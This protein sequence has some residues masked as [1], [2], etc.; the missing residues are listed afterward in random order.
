MYR[1]WHSS[2]AF[3]RYIVNHTVLSKLERDGEVSL[4][5]LPA[6][7]ASNPKTFHGVPTHLKQILYLD[8]PDLIVEL[9]N[10]PLF[11]VEVSEEAGTGH[12][13]FQRFG[14]IAAAVERGVPAFYIY[15]QAAHITRRGGTRW[16]RLNPTVFKT[17]DRLMEIYG[18]P[19]LLFYFPTDY[20]DDAERPPTSSPKGHKFERTSKYLRAPAASAPEMKALFRCIDAT[21]AK[22]QSRGVG[23]LRELIREGEIRS[24]RE[25]MRD[26]Y[27]AKG[28]NEGVWSPL[29]ATTTLP[30]TIV[31]DYIRGVVR[32]RSHI[33]G[34]L[35]GRP[36][37]VVYC[38]D[39]GFRGDPYPGALAAVDYLKCRTG[40]SYE[41]R[42]RNLV[43]AWGAL[44]VQDAKLHLTG[45]R[46]RSVDRF[47]SAVRELYR[48]KSRVLLDRRYSELA[49]ADIPRYYMQVRF[50][51]TFTKRKD[52]RMYSYFADALLFPDGV[53]WREG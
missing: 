22:V 36:E 7:D 4:H 43:L 5:D 20:D 53:L 25:W 24:R 3:G 48:D 40:T 37:T 50:G 12:N 16:D 28:G 51:T 45:D 11:S 42:E 38:A 18:I 19:A 44:S 14:R 26:E 30:T 6:S 2:Q 49:A 34:L 23:A 39:A 35:T 27:F 15:P 31:T 47:V 32:S 8:C 41:D 29:T 52:I 21:I 9:D 46:E 1:V 17:L 33:A 10:D 13:A